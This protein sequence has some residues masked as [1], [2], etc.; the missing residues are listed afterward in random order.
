MG[1]DKT[2]KFCVDTDNS[3]NNVHALEC[4]PLL[5]SNWQ[6]GYS[7]FT[8]YTPG[9]TLGSRPTSQRAAQS[10]TILSYTLVIPSFLIPHAPPQC[11]PRAVAPV[12]LWVISFLG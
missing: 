5:L 8:S 10:R 4:H 3:M 6:E 1:Q 9:L 2:Y 7:C 11:I 12:P